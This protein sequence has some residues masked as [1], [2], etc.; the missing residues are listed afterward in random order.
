MHSNCAVD[1][2]S[3]PSVKDWG[4]VSTVPASLVLFRVRDDGKLQFARKYDMET[5]ASRSLYWT[6]IVS[7]PYLDGVG[8]AGNGPA[9]LLVD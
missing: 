8:D 3:P 1:N 7:L 6:G 9:R 4:G 5:S 2:Q